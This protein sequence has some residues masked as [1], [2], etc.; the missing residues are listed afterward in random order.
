[1]DQGL[2]HLRAWREHCGL[3]QDALAE[4]S[5]QSKPF[6]SQLE[7]GHRRYTQDSLE[8]LARAL[9]IT[10]PELLSGPPEGDQAIWQVWN[11]LSG[12]DRGRGLELLRA[13]QRAGVAEEGAAYEAAS[14]PPGRA[15]RRS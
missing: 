10:P 6:I 14:P 9:G 12:P 3:T 4:R 15:K 8:A 7:N 13:L 5:G 2:P 11:T 1:M